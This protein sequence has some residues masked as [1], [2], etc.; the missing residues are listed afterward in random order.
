MPCR[1]PT[2]SL[3][4]AYAASSCGRWHDGDVGTRTAEGRSRGDLVGVTPRDAETGAP[5]SHPHPERDNLRRTLGR[6]KTDA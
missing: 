5:C 2:V 4:A 3:L 6:H 1:R